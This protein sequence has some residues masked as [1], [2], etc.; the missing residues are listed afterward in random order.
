MPSLGPVMSIVAGVTGLLTIMVPVAPAVA[1]ADPPGIVVRDGLTQPVFPLAEAIEERVWVQTGL[2]TDHDGVPDRVAIDISRP[3]ATA[4]DGL[5]VPVIFEHSPYRKDV[6]GDVPYPSVLVDE[7]PQSG[8]GAGSARSARSS[9]AR[10]VANLPGSLD[11]YY[12]PRGYAVVLGQSIGTGDSD[13]CPTSGDMAETLGTKA[14]IDWLNGRAMGYDAAGAPVTAS[15]T[16]GAVGMIGV[17]Y[18]GT[19]PNM[20]ATTGVTGLR[21][22]VPIAAISSWYD[23]YRAHGLVVAPG[24]YQGEDA[25]VLAKFTAGRTRAQGR[26]RDELDRL[27]AEQDR[28]TGDYTRFW[29]D[30]D[31]VDARRVRASV[32][33]VHGLQDWNVKTENFAGWW[34]EL[35]RHGVDRKIWL[36]QGG[37]GGPGNAAAVTLPDGRTWT[38]KQT[39]HRWFDHWLWNVDNGIMAEPTAVVQREDRGYRSYRDWPDPAARDVALRLSATTA[40]AP[41]DLVPVRRPRTGTTQSLVDEGRTIPPDELVADPDQASPNRLVYRTPP[42]AAEARLS[43][44]PEVVLRLSVDNRTAANV[45]AYLVEYGPPGTAADPVVVTRG[46]LDPQNRFGLANSRPVRP[47]HAYDLRWTLEPKDHVFRSGSR[48]GLVVFSSDQE[49]T[50]LPLGGTR[51]T[52]T[53]SFSEVRLPIVGG[54]AALGR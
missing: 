20:V 35:A 53:P 22:I 45:T 30:R 13:G 44:R 33:L 19:L 24:T 40:T 23:Y 52:V 27:T 11:D 5:K 41:G 48:I 25:D 36:H 1:A 32:F 6:W 42:L 28:V 43:G 12:V 54:A 7:L 29:R 14:V 50:L 31:Y 16:T 51:L 38:Y 26:C 34:D 46:W 17:S 4:T 8:V 49:Y 18:N 39:E 9:N 47:G 10:G 2:D 15:W 37:H 3:G 21:T